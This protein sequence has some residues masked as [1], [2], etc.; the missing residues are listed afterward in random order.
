M[1]SSFMCACVQIFFCKILGQ[2]N[3]SN[4]G[5]LVWPKFFYCLEMLNLKNCLNFCEQCD[6]MVILF[7]QFL[8]IQNT[9][10]L[11]K[12]IKC[13]PKQVHNFAKYLIVTQVMAK[14]FL[15]F[16]P[17][18][19][20]FAKS[21]H[22]ASYLPT[23]ERTDPDAF[24]FF[25]LEIHFVFN[26]HGNVFKTLPFLLYSLSLSLTHTLF[27]ISSI[28]PTYECTKVRRQREKKIFQY[29]LSYIKSK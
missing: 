26:Y 4:F 24:N 10:N 25:Q 3:C 22:T 1:V 13:L 29:K 21:G 14:N 15:N 6:Q 12:S 16:L 23:H 9:E 18:W 8:V 11:P 19:R 5:V 2:K 7:F 20:N 28:V 27:V 17:K